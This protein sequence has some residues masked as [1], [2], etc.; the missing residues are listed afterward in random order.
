MAPP[1]VGYYEERFV[2]GIH[3]SLYARATAFD[4]GEKRQLL[5][6]LTF[7]SL[8]RNIMIHLKKQLKMQQVFAKKLFLL[9]APIPTQA[10]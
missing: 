2:K 5:L 3:D 6:L 8:L 7:V 9:I 10:P 4:D 1:I